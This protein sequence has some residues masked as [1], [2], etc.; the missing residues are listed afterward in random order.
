MPRD[1]AGSLI[2]VFGTTQDTLAFLAGELES[3]G[4]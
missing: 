3:W 1:F 2:E 4:E